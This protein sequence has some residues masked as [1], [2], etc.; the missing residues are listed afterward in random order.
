MHI[1]MTSAPSACC[2]GVDE[3]FSQRL[4]YRELQ[5][6]RRRGLSRSTK[7][8]IN[9]LLKQDITGWTLLDIGGGIGAIQHAVL[10][11][12]GTSVVGVDASKEYLRALQEEALRLGNRLRTS[13]YHSDFV[14]IADKLD[15]A[16]IVTLDRVLCCYKDLES[17]V[18]A[19]TAKV[20]RVYGLVYPR[21][22]LLSRLGI[23]LFNASMWLT[24]KEF[25]THFHH[26]D[27]IHSL[28]AA[29]GLSE[30][31]RAN[32][33]LWQVEVYSR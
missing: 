26:P 25:R 29:A 12:G 1:P 17:L 21:G 8:L 7:K 3:F 9:A 19:S 30:S 20:R 11:A 23:F 4:A 33:L 18:A 10:D 15:T 16:D 28:V 14:A 32:T 24:R 5:T 31:Y 22:S 2:P 13:L 6:Y 27:K